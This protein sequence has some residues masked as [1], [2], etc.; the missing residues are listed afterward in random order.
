[1]LQ[2]ML[3]RL[4][5]KAPREQQRLHPEGRENRP[6]GQHHHQNCP[7]DDQ[8]AETFSAEKVVTNLFADVRRVELNF[9]HAVNPRRYPTPARMTI[10]LRW[11]PDISVSRIATGVFRLA[12]R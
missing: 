10:V 8:P 2:P 5:M 9:V 1:M 4:R 6:R 12:A 3:L 7:Q 11:V